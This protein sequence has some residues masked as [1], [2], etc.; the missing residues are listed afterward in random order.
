V[1]SVAG[2]KLTTY[3]V[4]AAEAVDRALA[5]LAK[6]G[7]TVRAGHANTD[8][9]P[10]PGGETAELAPF[11]ERA[12]EIGLAQATADHL[13]RHY[14]TESGGIVNLAAIHRELQRRIHPDHPAIEAEVI[15]TARRELAC[16]VEDVLVRRIH[17]Y[18]ETRDHGVAAASRVAQLL[19]GELGWDPEQVQRGA[20]EYRELVARTAAQAPAGRVSL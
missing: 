11:R 18:Y 10:L 3:R 6:R 15:H 2:G 9:E 12:G 20:A 17:L 13:V 16:K 8:E 1:I 14:G 5:E 4:M 7:V 19:G